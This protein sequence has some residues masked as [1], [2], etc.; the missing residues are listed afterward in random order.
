MIKHFMKSTFFWATRQK[1]ALV[2]SAGK[3]FVKSAISY[4]SRISFLVGGLALLLA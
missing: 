3:E 2:C 1:T 4:A